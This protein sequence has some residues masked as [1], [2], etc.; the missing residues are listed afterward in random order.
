MFKYKPEPN[1]QEDPNFLVNAL[2]Y[3]G[4]VTPKVLKNVLYFFIY[5]S[6]ITLIDYYHPWLH[7]PIEPFEYA[8]LVMGLIL[9][10]RM[11]AGHDRWWEARKI[12]GDVVN[13]SRNLGIILNNYTSDLKK[14]Q[15]IE[16]IRWVAVTPGIM[17]QVLRRDIHFENIQSLL[18]EKH[19][20]NLSSCQHPVL[21]VIDQI[22]ASINQM[23]KQSQ[24]DSFAFLKAEEQVISLI[25]S[26]GACERILNTPMPLVMAIK[27][28]R[29]LLFFL[30]LLPFGLTNDSGV[31][32]PFITAL[33]AYTLL[34]LDQIGIELQNPFSEESLSHLPLNDICET[35]QNNVLSLIEKKED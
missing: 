35:I 20:H 11:N 30:L 31:F 23:R 4:S 15:F 10:F 25:D 26:Q 16:I 33:V 24:I 17:K 7:F 2:T 6:F 12:W 34:A 27:A 28:R 22:S 3:H 1:K 5:A 29:F 14:E 21:Y 19:Y 18:S 13:K 9:V 8:G 32:S